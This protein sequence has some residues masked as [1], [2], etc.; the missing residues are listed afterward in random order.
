MK[1][2]ELTQGKI[3]LVDD[4]DFDY[5]SSFRWHAIQC[6]HS[7]DLWYAVH[8]ESKPKRRRISMHSLLMPHRDGHVVDHVS[9]DG[10]D[11]RRSN[12]RYATPKENM[13][14]QK[15]HSDSKSPYKGIWRAPRCD[16]WGVQIYHNKKRHYLGLFKD[17]VDAARVYDFVARQVF[18]PFARLNFPE[19]VS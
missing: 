18:G 17:P 10:L 1:R 15:R 8:Q 19:V 9:G 14:N 3:A 6:K 11:N 7:P 4:E 5:L 16:R 13:Q 12:L 2:I